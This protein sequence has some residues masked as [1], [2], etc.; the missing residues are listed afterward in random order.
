[1]KS[2]F[3]HE[4][5]RVYQESIRFVAWLEDV[6]LN[7]KSSVSAYDHLAR[8]SASV[9]VNIAVASGK[10]SGNEQRQFVDTAYGS[11]LECAACLDVLGILDRLPLSTVETGKNCL[12][13]IVSMLIRFRQSRVREVHEDNATYAT[14]GIGRKR[15]WFDHEKLDVY[16]TSL[17]MVA[18]CA[19]LIKSGGIDCL[20][21]S[22]LDRASTGVALNIA[23]GNG[24]FSA[25]D[26]CRFIGHARTA[27]LQAVATIDVL[28]AR[29][30]RSGFDIE[31]G[32]V[33]FADT[34]RMLVGWEKYLQ[35]STS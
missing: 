1:M 15:V 13:A 23:E 18:W 7:R 8:A 9:P 11:S 29:G 30:T 35:R 19:K 33:L 17:E 32:K 28:A 34:V 31:K 21:A 2:V 24:K 3:D 14:A 12:V 20:S 25:R 22:L 5:L 26:R 27:A 10:R 16:R 4:H 6:L